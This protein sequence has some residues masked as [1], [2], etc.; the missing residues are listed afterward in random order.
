M[1]CYNAHTALIYKSRFFQKLYARVGLSDTGKGGLLTAPPCQLFPQLRKVVDHHANPPP[2]VISNPCRTVYLAFGC[3]N[4]FKQLI[5]GHIANL[6]KSNSSIPFL[7]QLDLIRI[8]IV[9]QS[10][11]SNDTSF[12]MLQI[13]QS[14]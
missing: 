4:F 3:L 2:A 8:S 10:S 13:S 6:H 1:H 7:I 11:V 9:S 12:S 5:A 14:K